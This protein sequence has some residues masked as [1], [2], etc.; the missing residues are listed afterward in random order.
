MM[1][2]IKTLMQEHT[3][4]LKVLDALDR[5]VGRPEGQW[6]RV[7]L[8]KFV[9]FIREFADA[10]HHGKEE[11][12]LFRQM[13]EAGFPGDSGPIAVMLRDHEEG[14]RLVGIIARASESGAPD[15][16][17]AETVREAAHA[18]TR[19]LRGHIHKEDNIL[20]PMAA[21]HLPESVMKAIEERFDRFEA[22][23]TG[24]GRHEMLHALAEELIGGDDDP[25][26][27]AHDAS[28]RACTPAN[29][30]SDYERQ[31]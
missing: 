22:E 24:S 19:L 8:G 17:E 11:D 21:Q 5:Y 27:P 16:A 4:I 7:E 14:R 9:T 13:V 25:Y 3:V 31:P 29:Y 30:F 10:C 1:N 6:S 12:I 23:E 15:P 26:E 2:A 28:C 18:Y 20:Y